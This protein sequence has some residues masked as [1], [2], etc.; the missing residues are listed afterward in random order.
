MSTYKCCAV[1][2]CTNTTIK[3]PTKLFFSVPMDLNIRKKWFQLARRNP[4]ALSPKTRP[5]FCE[6]HF[7]IEE[8]TENFIQYNIMKEK[9]KKYNLRLKKGVLP[10]KFL[11][12]KRNTAS[13]EKN[14]ASQEKNKVSQAK[15]KASQEKNK[16]SQAKNKAS[17]VKNKASQKKN[18]AS[19]RPSAV[20]T[21]SMSAINKD[22]SR[23]R[24]HSQTDEITLKPLSVLDGA[25][26]QCGS[27][28]GSE[29]LPVPVVSIKIEPKIEFDCDI[30]EEVQCGSPYSSHLSFVNYHD[31]K[32]E[33]IDDDLPSVV[34][35]EAD[36][37]IKEEVEVTEDSTSDDTSGAD[38]RQ[39]DGTTTNRRS[40][41]TARSVEKHVQITP[42]SEKLFECKV[43]RTQFVDRSGLSRHRK[44]HTGEKLYKCDVCNNMYARKRH[45]AVHNRAHTS[46]KPFKCNMCL[47]TFCTKGQLTSHLRKHYR[48]RNKTIEVISSNNSV[49]ATIDV[50]SINPQSS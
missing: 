35:R 31:V 45:I 16:A 29:G 33:T 34:K 49:V 8:D 17:Q 30:K 10:H 11:C 40:E 36:A 38:K 9:P 22:T 21:R 1:P 6:D 19:H 27:L 23:V 12:Q 39:P 20:K 46:E 7:D 24:E 41:S 32:F 37:P 3:T 14:K 42:N 4:D 28:P 50:V 2:Q 13:Q 44:T 5:H 43:C 26:G 25:V 18:T 15:N 47:R 48:I